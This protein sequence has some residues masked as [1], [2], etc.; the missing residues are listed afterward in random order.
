MMLNDT[1]KMRA[2]DPQDMIGFIDDLPQQLGRAWELGKA[3]ALPELP[4]I[5]RVVIVGVGGSAI[6]ADLLNGYIAPLS[7]V[8]VTVW[9]NYE[10]PAFAD[11]PNT[12]LIA[13]SHSGNTEE[14]LS[15]FR[16]GLERGVSCVVITT[17]GT[18]AKEASA[19]DLP[20]WKFAHDG[21]PRTAV[22]Y[23]FGLLLSL[24]VRLGFVPNQEARIM[25]AIAAMQ[26]QQ[27]ELGI[28]SP[29]TKNPAKRMAWQMMECWPVILAAD[30]LA[31]VARRWRSQIAELAKAMAQF[32]ELPEAD[33][34]MLEAV[35]HPE[36]LHSNTMMVFLNGKKTHARNQLRAEFTKKSFMLAGL[37]TDWVEARGE[38]RMEQLWTAL[39]FGDY[40][41]YYLAMAYG[42]NPTPVPTMHELKA[43]LKSAT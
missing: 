28:D 7:K 23:S 14:V 26:L 12:L 1:E 10:L 43:Y 8:P 9:R 3:C 17:G 13:S 4:R 37:G 15:A 31:P 33:H 16:L 19:K 39:H 20:I 11:G 29:V 22:G 36:S 41:G 24:F 21:E 40:C 18:L 35:H 27:H 2:L 25:A 5:D 32:E 34:N 42:I 30:F 6:G 38:S